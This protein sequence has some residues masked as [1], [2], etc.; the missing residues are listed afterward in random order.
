MS[1]KISKQVKKRLIYAAVCLVLALISYAY[2]EFTKNDRTIEEGSLNNALEVHFIDVGQ[3][4][5]EL[6][7]LPDGSN[8]LIDAGTYEAV[9]D[10]MG[11]LEDNSVAHINLAVFTHPHTDHIGSAATV[12]RKTKVDRVLMSDT[13]A[14]SVS[15][16]KMLDE[17]IE[18]N[19]PVTEPKPG[20]SFSFGDAVLTVLGPNDDYKDVNETST[21]IKLTYGDVS[22]LF[23]GDAGITSEKDILKNGYDLKCDVLKLGHHGSSK[24]TGSK[25][26]D[27]VDPALA[28]ASCGKDNSYG[29]PHREIVDMLGNGNI[30]LLRTDV[31]GDIIV[32]TDGKEIYCSTEKG[33]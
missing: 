31:S 27:A 28:I 11:H 23:T 24:S 30:K 20:Q 6:I 9:N 26:L 29:H 32:S 2:S 5:C 7:M 12:L 17:I 3:G 14:T 10:I 21:V 16:E 22:F 8:I 18:K 4:D 19:I 33:Q 15:Y 1:Q 13:E 25:F